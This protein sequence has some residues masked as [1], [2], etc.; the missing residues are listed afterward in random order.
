MDN[1]VDNPDS[2]DVM[3]TCRHLLTFFKHLGHCFCNANSHLLP[4]QAGPPFKRDCKKDYALIVQV[5]CV[6]IIKV[7]IE[8]VFLNSAPV[9]VATETFKGLT[10]PRT[11]NM[12][13]ITHCG[14]LWVH[15]DIDH[16][17]FARKNGYTQQISASS[18]PAATLSVDSSVT[19]WMFQQEVWM[20]CLCSGPDRWTTAVVPVIYLYIHLLTTPTIWPL[21]FVWCHVGGEALMPGFPFAHFDFFS[22]L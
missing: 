1:I 3:R 21:H 20:S 6:T 18:F 10:S 15:G 4:W 22:G 8:T 9:P 14:F 2:L 5:N 17:H 19:Q 12:T 13:Q 7:A 11:S 16:P